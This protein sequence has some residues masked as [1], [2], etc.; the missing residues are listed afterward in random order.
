VQR[1]DAEEAMVPAPV[2]RTYAQTAAVDRGMAEAAGAPDPSDARARLRTLHTAARDPFAQLISAW[3]LAVAAERMGDAAD[4]EHWRAFLR[5]RAP[6]CRGLNE[7]AAPGALAAGSAAR[8]DYSGSGPSGRPA[9]R[10]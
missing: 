4:A 5:Q 1:A 9:D 8:D 3:G 7:T 10:S 2:R 6:H